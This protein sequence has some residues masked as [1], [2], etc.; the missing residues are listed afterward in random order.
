MRRGSGDPRSHTHT[1]QPRIHRLTLKRQHP[2]HTLMHAPQR[3]ALHKSL[4]RL[5]AQG[6][7]AKGERTLLF[8]A[9]PAQHQKEAFARLSRVC[10]DRKSTRLNSSHVRISYAVF[11]L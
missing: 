5:V 4:E 8:D 2:K 10:P 1:L 3:L 11:C 7:L 6:K 9:A